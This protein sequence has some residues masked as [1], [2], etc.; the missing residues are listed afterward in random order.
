MLDKEQFI[1]TYCS[2]S[3]NMSKVNKFTPVDDR[4]KDLKDIYLHL[5]TE[6]GMIKQNLDYNDY[7]RLSMTLNYLLELMKLK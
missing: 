5:A 6:L 3:S 7:K 4:T 2:G 1:K